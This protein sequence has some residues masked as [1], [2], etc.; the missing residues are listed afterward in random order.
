MKILING[1]NSFE[2]LLIKAVFRFMLEEEL[3]ESQPAFVNQAG[4]CPLECKSGA[5]Y[6]SVASSKTARAKSHEILCHSLTIQN[7]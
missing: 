2:W 4:R 5:G 6:F 1:I 3:T 7:P